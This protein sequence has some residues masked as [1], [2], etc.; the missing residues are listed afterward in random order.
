M[1]G[2][3][4]AQHSWTGF[5]TPPS[6]SFV[7]PT[8][9]FRDQID[10]DRAGARVPDAEYPDGYLGALRTRREDRLLRNLKHRQSQRSYTRGVHVGSRVPPQDY[11]WPPE[12]DPL[13]GLAAQ[14]AGVRQRPLIELSNEGGHLTN[15]GKPMP[16]G[17]RSLAPD[18]PARSIER[19]RPPWS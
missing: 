11:L 8:P 6:T 19:W 16:R 3:T 2:S 9:V 15:E 13:R 5:G 10:A 14:A 1:E 18:D 7:E 12:F 17:A 4:W